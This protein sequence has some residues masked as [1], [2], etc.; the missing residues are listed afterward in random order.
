MVKEKPYSEGDFVWV[1][2]I[3]HKKGLSPKLHRPWEGP[4]LRLGDTNY[5][6]QLNEKA[7]RMIV[8]R[9]RLNIYTGP[10]KIIKE[11]AGE[12]E[13]GSDL[14]RKITKLDRPKRNIR[15]RG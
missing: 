13:Q 9:D 2:C 14:K 15:Y 1:H 4:F 12:K 11:S 7:K 8:Q 6:V 10:A 3:K 5:V